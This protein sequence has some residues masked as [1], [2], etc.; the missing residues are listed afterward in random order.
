MKLRPRT[1]KKSYNHINQEQGIKA[2]D[3]QRGETNFWGAK[4]QPP[5]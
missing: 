2:P 5:K 1:T 4:Q 3:A